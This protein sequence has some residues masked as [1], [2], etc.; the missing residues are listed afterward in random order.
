MS[1]LN[2]GLAEYVNPTTQVA[3]TI[4][5]SHGTFLGHVLDVVTDEDSD[6]YDGIESIGLIRVNVIPAN[7]DKPESDARAYAYPMD[8][9]NYVLPLAG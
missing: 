1:S 8:R 5:K 2:K 7:Y 4:K 3:P 6:L 9:G